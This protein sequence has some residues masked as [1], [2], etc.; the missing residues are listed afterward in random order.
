MV[1]SPKTAAEERSTPRWISTAVGLT[2]LLALLSCGVQDQPPSGALYERV[3]LGNVFDTT[4][5]RGEFRPLRLRRSGFEYRCSECHEDLESPGR[6]GKLQAEHS[7]LIFDH[8]R[9]LNCLSCH[10]PDNR[11]TYVDQY[12]GEIP[13]DQP[14]LLCS[15][16]H[17]PTYRDWD[18]GVHGRQNGYWDTAQGERSKLLCI[19]CHDPHQPRF[20]EMKPDPPPHYSRLEHSKKRL[21][22]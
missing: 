22:E 1:S 12:G 5:V 11:N 18:I 4:P 7:D 14:A 17:G 20:T 3:V 13:A 9:N 21:H 8:G 19:Q 10:H 6:P 16:C 15:K 2:A